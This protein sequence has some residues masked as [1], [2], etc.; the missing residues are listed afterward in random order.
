MTKDIMFI[1]IGMLFFSGGNYRNSDNYNNADADDTSD[2]NDS[3]DLSVC[4][5]RM[6]KLEERLDNMESSQALIQDQIDLAGSQLSNASS[7]S[8]PRGQRNLKSSREDIFNNGECSMWVENNQVF[9]KGCNVHIVNSMG[10]NGTVDYGDGLGNLIIG[11]NICP[12]NS[13]F[14][15]AQ[16]PGYPNV[17]PT[18]DANRMGSHNIILGKEHIWTGEAVNSV[19][20]GQKNTIAGPNT[21]ILGGKLNTVKGSQN[22]VMGG[23]ENFIDSYSINSTI[24]GGLR[25]KI[26]SAQFSSIVGGNSNRISQSN[27]NSVVGGAGNEITG[28][29]SAILGGTD[30][31]VI[32]EDS[33]ILGGSGNITRGKNSVIVSGEN[34][35]TDGNHALILGGRNNYAGGEY[36][37]VLNGFLNRTSGKFAMV[38]TGYLNA[39][40]GDYSFIATGGGGNCQGSGNWVWCLQNWGN[41][42]EG[43]YSSIIGGSGNKAIGAYSSIVSGSSNTT[44]GNYAIVVGG[45]PDSKNI[46][47]LFRTYDGNSANGHYSVVVGGLSNKSI[48][49]SSA[50]FG[51]GNNETHGIGSVIAGGGGLIDVGD[52]TYNPGNTAYGHFSLVAGGA[53]N[54]AGN[55]KNGAIY[56]NNSSIVGG[57]NNTTR[58][59]YSNISGGRSNQVDN[60]GA[61]WSA[62]LGGV[63]NQVSSEYSVVLGGK[64]NVSGGH[65]TI[66]VGGMFNWAFDYLSSIFGGLFNIAGVPLINS[67]THTY[68]LLPP[69][70]D[71]GLESRSGITVVGGYNNRAYE[72][73]ATITG[74]YKNIIGYI[75][76]NEQY[77]I[78]CESCPGDFDAQ[79]Y[80]PLTTPFLLRDCTTCQTSPT[81]D[82]MQGYNNNTTSSTITGGNENHLGAGLQNL[83]YYPWVAGFGFDNYY[84]GCNDKNCN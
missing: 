65:A 58:A 10:L 57:Q 12:P 74:G 50:I 45:G 78:S 13:Q 23:Q 41:I 36:S 68:P 64:Y 62:I 77:C 31:T 15:D 49:N 39:A 18:V 4:N 67:I 61:S 21:A 76:S 46:F 73:L 27:Y 17:G 5:S 33:S 38:S 29:N 26:S 20:Y 60:E 43:S 42:T 75:N 7:Q 11:S 35:T 72:K 82:C 32:S 44:P 63:S 28:N 53:V 30:N 47:Q 6:E 16:N 48:G 80:Y 25:N 52:I 70:L 83:L 24:S 3:R 8:L 79:D 81:G 34:N 1:L 69:D 19:V 22:T 71:S 40:R 51:G 55:V 37:S 2:S 59:S 14:C 66:V 84:E 54:Q 9:F 56:G